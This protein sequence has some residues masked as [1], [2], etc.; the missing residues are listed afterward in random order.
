MESTREASETFT[1]SACSQEIPL[2]QKLPNY[3]R[4]R[5]C[6]NARTRARYAANPNRQREYQRAWH[7]RQ[8]ALGGTAECTDCHLALPREQFTTG[9]KQCRPCTKARRAETNSAYRAANKE[10]HAANSR[11]RYLANTELAKKNQRERRA[12]LTTEE[13]AARAVWYHDY[14]MANRAHILVLERERRERDPQVRAAY[15][16]HYRATHPEKATEYSRRYHARRRGADA[17][18]K[19]VTWH[20]VSERDGM[21]CA[22]CNV[23]CDSDDGHHMLARDGANRWVCGPTYPTIDHI[24]P[25]SLGGHHTMT[26][27]VL[28]CNRCNKRKGARP[29]A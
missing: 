13:R 20:S 12:A 6:R 16:R 5:D 19:G 7:D 1:C 8:R 4:C 24:V 2:A 10:Q 22:Y 25:V 14:Y 26:N 15:G 17:V 9:R 27:A 11:R 18:E 21:S 28:S 23:T 29:L 3:M